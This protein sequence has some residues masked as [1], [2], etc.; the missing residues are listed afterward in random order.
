MA[1]KNYIS[2]IQLYTWWQSVASPGRPRR[3]YVVVGRYGC[4]NNGDWIW[5]HVHLLQYG[6]EQPTQHNWKDMED[7]IE[8]GELIPLK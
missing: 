8:R 6:H 2:C 1:A 3:V 4:T 7:L 5:H